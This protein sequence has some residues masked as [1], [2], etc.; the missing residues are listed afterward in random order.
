[1]KLA[2]ISHTEHYRDQN[3]QIVGLAST[4]REINYL[5]KV[6][7]QIVHLAPLHAG[8]PPKHT[9]SYASSKIKFV[10]L[11]PAG[12]SSIYQKIKILAV[13]PSNLNTIRKEIKHVDF[14]QFRS[15]TAMGL[16]VLPFLKF[17]NLKP[18]WV[19]YAGNWTQKSPPWSYTLQ[20]WWLKNITHAKVTINGHWNG[21]KP[22]FYSFENPCLSNEELSAAIK[23]SQSK[24]FS[25]KI[26]LLFVGRLD[27]AKGVHHIFNAITQLKTSDRIAKL[28]LV[29]DST[30][31]ETYTPLASQ[32]K[33]A[34]EFLGYL[35]RAEINT[36][37]S[38]SHFL[39]LPSASEGFP[40]V[41]AE[42]A[43]FGCI[44]IV[45]KISC[46]PQ[47]IQ[48]GENGFL[49][50]KPYDKELLQVLQ[51][52]QELSAA[53]LHSISNK[54]KNLSV[55]FTY[56]RYCKRLLTEICISSKS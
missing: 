51:K 17:F 43:A 34:V 18:Y 22:N 54:A 38:M 39:L 31:K 6:F 26:N 9:L 21:L 44:P 10:A 40:K 30:N 49:L 52:I 3:G 2:I 14:I 20:R 15:P 12:G 47:Y 19:K 56:A 50:N 23:A 37:Y 11:K 41:I 32:S 48:H 28:Y 13:A 24:R 35:S 45:S 8:P 42:A 25:E 1:M 29:G 5:S 55:D 4:L 7:S 36:Y 27:D 33:V 46:I 16:Y 53:E